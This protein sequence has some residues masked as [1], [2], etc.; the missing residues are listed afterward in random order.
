MIRPTL[1]P[2]IS[3]S[4]MGSAVGAQDESML[5][6][7]YQ[8]L[9]LPTVL[10]FDLGDVTAAG[11]PPFQVGPWRRAIR[12]GIVRNA[13]LVGGVTAGTTLTF[14][15][16]WQDLAGTYY[17]IWANPGDRIT[18]SAIAPNIVDKPAT[19]AALLVDPDNPT[20]L[21][22]FSIFLVGFT[23]VGTVNNITIEVL[24]DPTETN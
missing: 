19:A 9:V 20:K 18:T 2:P 23:G 17:S 4:A 24:I 15:I 16:Y 10:T 14:D 7:Y 3:L 6:Q 12:P 21:G 22:L 5:H 8:R 1:L 13:R 11:V